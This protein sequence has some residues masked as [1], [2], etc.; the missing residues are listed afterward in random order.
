MEENAVKG[1]IVVCERTDDYSVYDKR[2]TVKSLGG[3]GVVIV[4]DA[5]RAVA[6]NYKSFPATVVGSKD[7]KVILS[8][9]NSTR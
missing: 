6:E 9:I 4:D 7:A 3:L 8:Y 2:D 1:K 5:S